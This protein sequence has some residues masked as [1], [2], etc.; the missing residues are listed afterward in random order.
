MMTDNY[1]IKFMSHNYDKIVKN[2][3]LLFLSHNSDLVYLIILFHNLNI[4]HQYFDFL[5]I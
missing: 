1:E 2:Y 5:C 3:F 4:L